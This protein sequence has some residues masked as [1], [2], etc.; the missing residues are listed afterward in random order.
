[1]FITITTEVYATFGI[2]ST[3]NRNDCNFYMAFSIQRSLELVCMF[4]PVQ[5]QR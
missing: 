1:V 3:T 5:Q 2:S 4:Q